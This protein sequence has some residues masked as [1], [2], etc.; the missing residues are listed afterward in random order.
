MA[1]DKITIGKVEIIHVTD[2]QFI[3]DTSMVF[4]STPASAF[5]AYRHLLTPDG[6][7]ALNVGSYVLRSE[8]RTIL[9]DTGIGPGPTMGGLKGRL[10]DDMRDKGVRPEE[11]D[12]VV[13]THLHGDHIGWNVTDQDGKPTPTFPRARYVIQQA[14]WDFFTS[15]ERLAQQPA[16]GRPLLPLKDAGVLDLHS[17]E[18]A[19]TG[20]VSVLQTPGHTPG[21]ASILIASAGE[22]AVIVGDV[23]NH[24]VQV[25]E[26]DWV[27]SF[28]QDGELARRTRHQLLGR[29]QAEGMTVAAGHFPPPGYGRLILLEGKRHWQAL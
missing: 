7:L 16:A 19:L 24:P 11:I 26:P 4:P 27:P 29:L 18:H 3:F 10:P 21:H 14:D 17:D 1:A 13:F 8:G 9:V 23:V 6:K 15:A 28:D 2:A 12:I 20:E 22:R 5:E 25:Y